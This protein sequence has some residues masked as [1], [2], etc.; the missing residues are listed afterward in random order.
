MNYTQDTPFNTYYDREFD[1]WLLT[2][3]G[4]EPPYKLPY[5]YEAIARKGGAF[6]RRICPSHKLVAMTTVSL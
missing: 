1:P 2:K 6:R 4:D 5:I 3:V